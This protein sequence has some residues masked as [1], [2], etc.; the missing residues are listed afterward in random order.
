MTDKKRKR[1]VRIVTIGIV[2]VLVLTV[3]IV[4]ALMF[5]AQ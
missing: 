1:L 5:F 4:P 2:A 3:A